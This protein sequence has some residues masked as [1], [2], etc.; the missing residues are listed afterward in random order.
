MTCFRMIALD[1]GEDSNDESH[2]FVV[3]IAI[4]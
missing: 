3:W 2:R 4:V 1:T